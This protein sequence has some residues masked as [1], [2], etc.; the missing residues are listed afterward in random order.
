M[1]HIG[2]LPLQLRKGDSNALGGEGVVFH[3][4][5]DTD[6]VAVGPDGKAEDEPFGHA[7]LAL[8]R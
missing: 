5:D 7:V 4:L 8:A 2:S 3:A 1:S 6:Y